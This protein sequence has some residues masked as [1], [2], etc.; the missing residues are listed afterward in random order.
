[1]SRSHLSARHFLN[2]ADLDRSKRRKRD[3]RPAWLTGLIEFAA[4][5]FE[6]LI[7]VGR[8]GFDCRWDEQGWNVALYL[9][10]TEHVGGKEDGTIQQPAFRFDLQPL[11]ER[12]TRIDGLSWNVTPPESGTDERPQCFLLV[13]GRIADNRVRL[14]IH[15]AAPLAAGPGLRRL[16][17]GR[18]EPA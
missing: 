14:A 6:P 4:E 13:D 16:P 2:Q 8:V 18:V 1:M 10:T 12:F 5:L 11:L 17:D 9:G 15:A 7:D 3:I